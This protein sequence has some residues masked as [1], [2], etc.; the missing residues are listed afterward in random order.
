VKKNPP[1]VYENKYHKEKEV[2]G[3]MKEGKNLAGMTG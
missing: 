3:L 2:F 1:K